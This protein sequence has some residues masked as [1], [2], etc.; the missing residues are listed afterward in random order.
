VRQRLRGSLIGGVVRRYDAHHAG[1]WATIIAWNAF[2]SFVPIVIAVVALFSFLVN[3]HDFAAQVTSIVDRIASSRQERVELLRTIN[4]V[5]QHRN[6]L[7]GIAAVGLLWSGSA[8]FSAM[9]NGLSALYG[10]AARRFIIKRLRGMFLVIIFAALLVPLLLS[11]ALLSAGTRF[12]LLPT[13]VPAPALFALQFLSGTILATVIFL[14]I[15]RL[16]PNSGHRVRRVMPGALS[17]GLLLEAL[18][19]LFPIYER[20]TN[21]TAAYGALIGLIVLL[22]TFFFVL[23]QITVI[24]ALVNVELDA[25]RSQ[26]S[27]SRLRQPTSTLSCAGRPARP[28]PGP[29]RSTAPPAWPRDGPRRWACRRL[30]SCRRCR[31]RGAPAQPAAR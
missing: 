27:A 7:A 21:G 19:G 14:V 6:L 30:G 3:R 15:Y 8:L 28:W 9:D 20:S 11:S 4:G 22:L 24:G 25:R 26:L 1:D 18:T 13:G 5:A 23:G 12:S 10:V 31:R 2:F 17:A 29:P 16:L